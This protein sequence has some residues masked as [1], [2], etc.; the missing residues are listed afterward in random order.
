ME[1]HFK[2][3]F[4]WIAL[5]V[6]KP[7][8]SL[9][10]S[11]NNDTIFIKWLS[12]IELNCLLMH[13]HN[14]FED[15]MSDPVCKSHVGLYSFM[16]KVKYP[17]GHYVYSYFLKMSMIVIQFVCFCNFRYSSNTLR[18][19]AAEVFLRGF[20]ILITFLWQSSFCGSNKTRNTI[21]RPSVVMQWFCAVEF[22][23]KLFL[24]VVFLPVHD[25]KF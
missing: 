9:C 25:C 5:R 3:K 20:F 10:I 18:L 2:W 7:N 8:G 13:N 6:C 12:Y 24:L 1:A 14:F 21:V 15:H 17:K 23:L 22:T 4:F 16:F 19:R 11:R